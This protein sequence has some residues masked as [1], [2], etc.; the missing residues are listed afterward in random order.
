MADFT[1][2][3]MLK[4]R[5]EF[6]RDVAD[7]TQTPQYL[8]HYNRAVSGVWADDDLINSLKARIERDLA[9]ELQSVYG[10]HY[11]I[12]LSEDDTTTEAA[13][14]AE[15]QKLDALMLQLRAAIFEL[16]LVDAGYVGSIADA[17]ARLVIM[18]EMKDAIMAARNWLR[19]R[20]GGQYSTVVLRRR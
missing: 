4:F 6:I 8:S 17:E 9:R 10:E 14:A 7:V 5:R 12:R 2:P 19:A 11:Q 13:I 20:T 15:A 18:N 16:M 3:E 1:A